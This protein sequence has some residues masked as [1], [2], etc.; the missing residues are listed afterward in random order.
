MKVRFA[1]ASLCG[2][3]RLELNVISVIWNRSYR[4][5][6][7]EN[8]MVGR[9][10]RRVRG[11]GPQPGRGAEGRLGS[12]GHRGQHKEEIP[13]HL[14]MKFPS[15]ACCTLDFSLSFSSGLPHSLHVFSPL[16][17]TLKYEGR[18]TADTVV[19]LLLVLWR[20]E[21]ENKRGDPQP[22]PSLKLGG[23]KGGRK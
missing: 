16:P 10:S 4:Q 13:G 22:A 21:R 8:V 19:L 2:P 5:G 18:G 14:Q 20:R 3:K 17:L 7:G 9:G 1:G 12:A 6:T 15:R 23:K 11:E